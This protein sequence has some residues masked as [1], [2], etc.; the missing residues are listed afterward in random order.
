MVTGYYGHIRLVGK[1]SFVFPHLAEDEDS[2]DQDSVASILGKIRHEG[3]SRQVLVAGRSPC[4]RRC[5]PGVIFG[6]VQ[7]PSFE[8]PTGLRSGKES[9]CS[10]PMCLADAIS[11]CQK[12]EARQLCLP[13]VH[14][15][16]P[17]L[18]ALPFW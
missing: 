10:P 15:Y 9:P 14:T 6:F 4:E 18:P 12:E 7:D 13:V 11:S 8:K 17:A 16:S 5:E 1:W 2:V 3:H